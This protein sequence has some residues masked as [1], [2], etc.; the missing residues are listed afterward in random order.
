MIRVG[1]GHVACR[2]AGGNRRA[3][4]TVRSQ[5]RARNIHAPGFTIHIHRGLVGLGTDFHRHRITGFDVVID[6]PR[7]RNR[8]T[9][10]CRVND[11]IAGHIID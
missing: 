1:G 8:L 5:H 2:I 6:L 7:H 10:L 4:I 9:G 3:H 11:V